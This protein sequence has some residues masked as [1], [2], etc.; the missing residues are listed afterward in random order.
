MP[1]D[2]QQLHVARLP[3]LLV[4]N[5]ELDIEQTL[6]FHAAHVKW[7]LLTIQYKYPE[8]LIH[9]RSSTRHLVS[10]CRSNAPSRSSLFP[11]C[12]PCA[13][14]VSAL[15]ALTCRMKMFVWSHLVLISTGVPVEL[16]IL[17]CPT[18]SR[19]TPS[20]TQRRRKSSVRKWCQ[21]ICCT[22]NYMIALHFW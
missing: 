16:L 8:K 21:L 6:K 7:D 9:W 10:K 20:H 4:I 3:A 13:P 14:C 22:L 5:L 18:P 19:R 12:A 2:Q 11:R 15:V 17:T 1:T